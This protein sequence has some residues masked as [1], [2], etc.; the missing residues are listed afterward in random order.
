MKPRRWSCSAVRGRAR[1]VARPAELGG[2]RVHLSRRSPYRQ[3]LLELND[4][5]TDDIYVVEVDD[6]VD[7]L[8]QRLAEGEIGYTVAAENVAKLKATEYTNLI[9]QPALGPPRQVV[10]AVRRNA[11]Q[12]HDALNAWIG[13][14]K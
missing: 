9:V 1:L 11:P 12:L 10:W 4:E 5:L 14:E 13:A 8:I 3:T 6:S 7:R 2:Q